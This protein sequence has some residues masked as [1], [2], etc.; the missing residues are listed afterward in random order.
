MLNWKDISFQE[1]PKGRGDTQRDK[2]SR[3]VSESPE[4]LG[5]GIHHIL[6]KRYFLFPLTNKSGEGLIAFILQG[7]VGK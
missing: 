1:W 3:G 5:L 6:N 2:G 7:W 4:G